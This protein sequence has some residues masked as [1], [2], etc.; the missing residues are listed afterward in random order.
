MES[1]IGCGK[2]FEVCGLHKGLLLREKALKPGDQPRIR[3]K[4]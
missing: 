2:G 1:L 3:S 4:S